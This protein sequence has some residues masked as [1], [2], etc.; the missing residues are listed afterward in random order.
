MEPW[1]WA[2]ILLAAGLGLSV[3]EVFLPSGGIISFLAAAAVL[4]AII[5]AFR[6]GS[7]TGL[8]ILSIAIVAIPIVVALALRFWPKTA[9]GRRM[10]LSSP[11][12]DEILSDNPRHR[13]LKGLV[14]RV[15]V[16]K[17]KM[18]PSGAVSID[19]RTIDALSE[20]FPIEIGQ[21]VRVIEARGNRVVVRPMTDESPEANEADPLARPIDTVVPDPFGESET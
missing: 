3:L 14:G 19:G 18:I 12:G 16:A 13:Y 17:S 4:A 8:T 10:L 11:E 21:R 20:G 1:I 5:V 9:I 6:E 2:V 7:G 15:G